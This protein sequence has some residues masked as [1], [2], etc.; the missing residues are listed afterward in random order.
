[1]TGHLEERGSIN[2]TWKRRNKRKK[3]KK[4]KKKRR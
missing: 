4:R 3:R 2:T 1:M